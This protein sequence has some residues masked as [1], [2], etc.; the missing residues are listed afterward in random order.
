MCRHLVSLRRKAPNGVGC[1]R[2]YNLPHGEGGHGGYPR[3]ILKNKDLFTLFSRSNLIVISY[4]VELFIFEW[5]VQINESL[6]VS[7]CVEKK[8]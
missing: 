8:S 3:E 1:G 6:L 5:F 4:L 7:N 2:G